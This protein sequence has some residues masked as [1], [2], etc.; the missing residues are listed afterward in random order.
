MTEFKQLLDQ[1][2][3]SQKGASLLLDVRYDTV[4]S[5]YYG[6]NPV[7]DGVIA[8]LRAYA[9]QAGK[10]FDKEFMEGME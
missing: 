9:K 7:P 6:R 1:C 10:I 5:W 2:G 4:K 3:V 8:D